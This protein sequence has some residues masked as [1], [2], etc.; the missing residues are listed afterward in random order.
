MNIQT[1]VHAYP[2]ITIPTLPM[3]HITGGAGQGAGQ[4]PDRQELC[5]V[6]PGARGPF[7]AQRGLLLPGYVI[8]IYIWFIY[9][10]VPPTST[11]VSNIHPSA[12]D[13]GHPSP[14]SGHISHTHTPTF[15]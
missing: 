15:K 2:R 12:T 11:A 13:R 4:H 8:C 6:R 3:T 9:V 7:P 10:G 1:Y 5:P 14:T